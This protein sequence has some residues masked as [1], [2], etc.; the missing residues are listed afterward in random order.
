MNK[1]KNSNSL[2]TRLGNS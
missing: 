1:T 2:E